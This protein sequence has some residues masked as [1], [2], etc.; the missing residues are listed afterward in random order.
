MKITEYGF[1]LLSKLCGAVSSFI[2]VSSKLMIRQEERTIADIT[3][4]NNPKNLIITLITQIN[5]ITKLT[6]IDAI[7]IL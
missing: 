2:L 4:R 7:R 1:S 5:K 3:L 6:P